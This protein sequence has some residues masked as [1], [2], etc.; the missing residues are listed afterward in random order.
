MHHLFK[1]T[2]VFVP[3]FAE[4]DKSVL[5]VEMNAGNILRIHAQLKSGSRPHG[6]FQQLRAYS[7][8]LM[9]R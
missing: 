7:A 9:S 3:L 4:D 6:I 5:L 1:V 2:R 8:A